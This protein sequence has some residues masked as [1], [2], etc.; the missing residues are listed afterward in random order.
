MLPPSRHHDLDATR[1]RVCAKVR[2]LRI[3]RGWKQSELAGKLGL[4]QSRLSQIER[5]EGSFTA[6]QLIEVL[7]LFNVTIDQ[8]A[9]PPEPDAELQNALAR[10]GALHL[11]ES[12]LVVP[13]TRY[14]TVRD[15]VREVLLAPNSPR[16]VTALAPV[17]V[18]NID[19]IDLDNTHHEVSSVGRGRRLGWLVENIVN[20][21][22]DPHLHPPSE[23][24]FR[25][26]VAGVTLADFLSRI[27]PGE[28]PLTDGL[29]VDTFEG[30]VA[31]RKTLDHLRREA[32]PAS[33]RWGV[34]TAIQTADF[35][36]ALREAYES[37]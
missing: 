26:R 31:S 36:H 9:S 5:G 20:A 24:A 15:A 6:E 28:N 10:L 29:A 33:H 21:L 1:R 25:Q 14:G 3:A 27:K 8:F 30:G 4:S 22:R 32:S 2:D 37:D 13:S 19:S 18:W 11:R 23:W 12:S 35:V 16:L 7:R 17:V 34:A